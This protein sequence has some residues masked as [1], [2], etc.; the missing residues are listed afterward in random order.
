MVRKVWRDGRVTIPAEI[1]RELGIEPGSRVELIPTE[2]GLI[3]R[4]LKGVM[5]V[6]GSLHKYAKYPVPDWNEVREATHRAVAEEVMEAARRSP[7]EE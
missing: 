4:P 3:I 6:A 2:D 7:D 5:E 1:R